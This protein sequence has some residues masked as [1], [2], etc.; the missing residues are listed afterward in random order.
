VRRS[1]L[2]KQRSIFNVST[3]TQSG[4]SSLEFSRKIIKGSMNLAIVSAVLTKDKIVRAG[5][6]NEN[7]ELDGLLTFDPG[8]FRLREVG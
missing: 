4:D 6:S 5:S 3:A 1:A 8:K 7:D 2:A